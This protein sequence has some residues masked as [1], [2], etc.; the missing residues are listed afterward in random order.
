[1]DYKKEVKQKK[2]RNTFRLAF[3]LV[4]AAVFT[5]APT[6]AFA[7]YLVSDAQRIC[8]P[9]AQ[10]PGIGLGGYVYAETC[11]EGYT[12]V[13]LPP[14]PEKPWYV[15]L[16]EVLDTWLGLKSKI[17]WIPS[18]S[19]LALL[20]SLVLLLRRLLQLFQIPFVDSLTHGFG[21]LLISAVLS[22]LLYVQPLVADGALTAYEAILALLS[23][24]AGAAGLWEVIKR[25][26]RR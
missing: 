3:A 17:I 16:L 11:P 10:N 12:I 6:V 14:T 19:Q 20:A 7:G 22:F 25:L 5:L 4:L 18:A 13:E 2:N 8:V 21:T 1:M 23:T 9:V 26:V 24:V 15:R